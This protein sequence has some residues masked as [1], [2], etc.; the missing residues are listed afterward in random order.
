MITLGTWADLGYRMVGPR[1]PNDADDVSSVRGLVH[2]LATLGAYEKLEDA[3]KWWIRDAA[4]VKTRLRPDAVAVA[5]V[6]DARNCRNSGEYRFVDSL[7]A[8]KYRHF[9]FNTPAAV[10]H[11]QVL[12]FARDSRSPKGIYA[13]TFAVFGCPIQELK[14]FLS[15]T[16]LPTFF[17]VYPN[18]K[19]MFLRTNYDFETRH[20]MMRA[21]Y[22]MSQYRRLQEFTTTS[23]PF[24]TM[25]RWQPLMPSVQL[26][27]VLE[28]ATLLFFPRQQYFTGTRSGL[29]TVFIPGAP[30]VEYGQEF[31][32]S[33][34]DLFSDHWDFAKGERHAANVSAVPSALVETNSLRPLFDRAVYGALEIEAL[35]RWL[36][37]RYNFF[38]FH[39]TDPA[40]FLDDNSFIDF[41]TCFE[42]ALT[43]DRALRKGISCATST[44]S[45]VRK[46]AAMEIVDIVSELAHYWGAANSAP[47]YFKILVH[48]TQARIILKSAFGTI[49]PP[50]DAIFVDVV[51]TIYDQLRDSII[52]SVFVPSKKTPSG[53][54][55][56]AKDLLSENVESIDEFTANVIRSLR[57]THH[58]Y[59]TTNDRS[60]RPSR[61]LALVTGNLPEVFARFG[62]LLALAAVVAPA[63]VFGWK[64]ISTG[65]FP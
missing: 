8:S 44:E 12:K 50:F 17:D 55:V 47:D 59:L 35:V 25:E 20:S 61:Y 42:H 45:V 28:L 63:T 13:L 29:I 21:G 11:E 2:A 30:F 33:W 18:G 38:A 60:L 37:D 31:P 4:R 62:C 48:P 9:Q 46:E 54:L 14:E 52:D 43:I 36:V 34:R 57:N 19:V 23:N 32:A 5:G 39:Q 56:R 41:V 64:P 24:R 27:L 26:R 65:E 22:T 58:G 51:D 6:F 1:N 7:A 16:L 10:R 15:I 53:V 49:T 3:G 40:E